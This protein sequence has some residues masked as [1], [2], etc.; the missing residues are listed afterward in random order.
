EGV[1]RPVPSPASGGRGRWWRFNRRGKGR[2]VAFQQAA[3]GAATGSLPRVRGGLG[4]GAGRVGA[5]DGLS[6]VGCPHPSLPPHAG[7]GAGGGV[8]TSG[9]GAGGGVS[10]GGISGRCSEHKKARTRRAFS[11]VM[12]TGISRGRLPRLPRRRPPPS[13]QLRQ[14]LRGRQ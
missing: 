9:G 3:A 11:P 6:P 10:T 1:Q 13:R 12:P 4:V 2:E 7:E 14:R 8:S 5:A